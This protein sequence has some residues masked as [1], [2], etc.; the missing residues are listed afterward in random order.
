VT[1]PAGGSVKLDYTCTY[2]SKPTYSGTN[3]AVAVW[4][5]SNNH[6]PSG[7]AFDSKAFT[8]D[9]GTAGNPT[10]VYRTVTVTDTFNGGSPTPLGT[11]GPATTTQ[12]FVTRQFTYTR[13]ITVNYAGLSAV[14]QHGE[15]RRDRPDCQPDRDSV[16]A[17]EHRRQD[18][19]FL[20]EQEWPSDHYPYSIDE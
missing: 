17:Q 16:R 13:T 2:S 1:V 12:P 7:M 19:R 15:N 8:F 4:S 9:D 5:A 18:H 11:V 20:A 3:T 6:T 10:N 14:Q